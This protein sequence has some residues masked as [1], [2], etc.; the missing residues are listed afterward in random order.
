M[1]S[2]CVFLLW[3]LIDNGQL[4]EDYVNSLM[5]RRDLLLHFSHGIMN[6]LGIPKMP[7]EQ[8]MHLIA[9]MESTNTR[10]VQDLFR[11]IQSNSRLS[12]IS[13]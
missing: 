4:S 6:S 7:H 12:N 13:F 11:S 8:I 2:R 3:E 1:G 5:T 10:N 9:L